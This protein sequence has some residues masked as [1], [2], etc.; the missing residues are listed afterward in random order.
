MQRITRLVAF[1]F[2]AVALWTTL[3][4]TLSAQTRQVSIDAR[5]QKVEQVLKE[6]ERETGYGFFY[7]NQ[8]IDL[9]RRVSV[10]A[11]D[12]D[13]MDVLSQVFKGTDV[14]CEI[15]GDRIVLT[16]KA[17][18]GDAKPGRKTVSGR[19]VDSKG[20]PVAGVGV[21]ESGTT[22][23]VITDSEGRFSIEVSGPDALLDVSS[24][25][26]RSAEIP[27]GQASDIVL[28]D[29][30]Q[31]LEEVVVIGY[32]TVKKSDLTGSVASISANS[33]KDEPIK[34]VEDALQGRTAGVAVTNVSGLPGGEIKIRVRGTT[35]INTSNDP[36]YVIDGMVAGGLMV[37]T[38]D[39][40][41]I[42]VLK[43]ASATAIYGSR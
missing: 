25:G 12:K 7:S 28:Q 15:S 34:R 9:E 43:D 8:Q 41:S 18:E 11:K 27:A 4:M 35:S 33:F 40:E 10:S 14:R 29:D 37:N 38:D 20:V 19:I 23:G 36:L 42:E 32:G 26:Y 30:L 3:S 1:A 16:T 6:I 24:I 31:S 21:V 39:I 17:K 13:V 5:N 22:N 2:A